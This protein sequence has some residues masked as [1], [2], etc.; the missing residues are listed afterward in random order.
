MTDQNTSNSRTLLIVGAL[1]ALVLIAGVLAILSAGSSDSDDEVAGG[2]PNAAATISE[3]RPVTVMG[4][5]LPAMQDSGVDAALGMSMPELTGE[6]FS[7]DS[8][9]ILNDGKPKILIFLAHW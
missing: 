1:A 5:A 2:D 7:G 8:V 4:T 9:E 3:T 6:S